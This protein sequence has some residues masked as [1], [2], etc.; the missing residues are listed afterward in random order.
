MHKYI[1]SLYLYTIILLTP[2]LSGEVLIREKKY[3]IHI[4]YDYKEYKK[5]ILQQNPELKTLCDFI[6]FIMEDYQQNKIRFE[7]LERGKFNR[8]REYCIKHKPLRKQYE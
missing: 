6:Y 7:Y 8:D 1:I 2:L 3:N 4:I 5:L